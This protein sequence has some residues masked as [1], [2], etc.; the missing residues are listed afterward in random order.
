MVGV[1]GVGKTT[2]CA[3]IANYF[4]LKNNKVSLVTILTEHAVNQLK[5]WS[6]K[7]KIDFISNEMSFRL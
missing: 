7:L 1:N 6:D 5:L 4:K 3:K 2:S